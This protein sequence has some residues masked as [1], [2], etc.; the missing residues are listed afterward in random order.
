MFAIND[1]GGFVLPARA[2]KDFTHFLETN[3]VACVGVGQVRSPFDPAKVQ[4]LYLEWVKQRYKRRQRR[5]IKY[6]IIT[7]LLVTSL[8]IVISSLVLMIVL[9]RG[10]GGALHGRQGE[11][12][13]AHTNGG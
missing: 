8:F 6:I 2:D 5:N 1:D 4:K 9:T 7:L 12:S 11:S 3:G 13:F 10:A